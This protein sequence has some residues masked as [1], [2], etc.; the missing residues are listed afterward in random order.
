MCACPFLN[1]LGVVVLE[2]CGHV[3]NEFGR[4]EFIHLSNGF[5]NQPAFI[6]KVVAYNT[7]GSFLPAFAVPNGVFDVD[8][9]YTLAQLMMSCSSSRKPS[10]SIVP[11]PFYSSGGE[12]TTSRGA[13]KGGRSS[14]PRAHDPGS[15]LVAAHSSQR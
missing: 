2:I 11:T 9:V 5:I 6:V 7:R 1:F 3:V 8:A 14:S 12:A 4:N 15:W 13:G 10:L